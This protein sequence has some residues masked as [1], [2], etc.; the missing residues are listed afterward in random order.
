MIKTVRAHQPWSNLYF[1]FCDNPTLFIIFYL[2][3]NHIWD[4]SLCSKSSFPFP[5]P[6]LAI[7]F[8][9]FPQTE[10]LF[11]GNVWWALLPGR[12]DLPQDYLLAFLAAKR[13]TASDEVA[14]GRPAPYEI[15]RRTFFK[16][17]WPGARKKS[18]VR[19]LASSLMSILFSST[20]LD[21]FCKQCL[22]LMLMRK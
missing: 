5:F 21:L 7:F 1:F 2:S 17:Y 12:V 8:P 15:R 4:D 16:V 6:L 14:R 18:K 20:S 10:S 22:F 19:N 3:F 9:P 13:P 11:T